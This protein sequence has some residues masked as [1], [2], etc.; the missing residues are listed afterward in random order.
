[1]VQREVL[2]S[3]T[4]RTRVRSTAQDAR[5]GAAP[6]ANKSTMIMEKNGLMEMYLAACSPGMGKCPSG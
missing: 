5:C 6:Q 1:M 3:A 2:V 4:I